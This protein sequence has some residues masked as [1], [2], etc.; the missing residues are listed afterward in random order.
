VRY[1]GVTDID[2]YVGQATGT[3]YP[4]GLFRRMGYVDTRDLAGLLETV[5]D[6]L[7]VFERI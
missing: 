1:T 4:F 3:A 5:E 6:G 2:T 7:V